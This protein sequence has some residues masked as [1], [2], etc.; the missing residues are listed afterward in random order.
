MVALAHRKKVVR[1]FRQLLTD[2]EVFE[3]A[4]VE[5]G[6]GREAVWQQFLED[7]PWILGISLA[8]QLLISWDDTKLEQVV[9]GFSVAGPGKRT[10]A[11]LRTSGRI[12]SLVF[13]EIKHHET[14]LLGS[15]YAKSVRPGCWPV[16]SD[17]AGG[18]I[19]VQRTVDT[20][21]RQIGERLADTDE[22]GADT[23][24]ETWL[25]RPR[26]FL[27]LGHLDQLCGPG[28]VHRPKFHSFEL[29]RRNLVEPEIVTFDELLARAE[30]HIAAAESQTP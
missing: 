18:V 11:L 15:E 16:S 29:Y 24:E 21:V 22:Y 1:R 9:T 26:S 20:A 23:G 30:W 12:R 6:K 4:Q 27:I 17:L 10:D 28:G 2:Q 13:A 8:G 5:L 3:E 19:Q 25:I 7:H 14:H